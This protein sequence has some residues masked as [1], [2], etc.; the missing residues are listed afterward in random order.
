MPLDFNWA[1]A[2]KYARAAAVD[3][4]VAEQANQKRARLGFPSEQDK[5]V[6][7]LKAGDTYTVRCWI[8]ETTTVR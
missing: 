6:R 3:P 1:A 4:S 8:Q 5:F 2:D 7:G